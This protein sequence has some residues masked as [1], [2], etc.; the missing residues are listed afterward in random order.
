MS[1]VGVEGY[2]GE[3]HG[4]QAHHVAWDSPLLPE[5]GGPCIEGK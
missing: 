5:Q 3:N 4:A 1:K 2:S